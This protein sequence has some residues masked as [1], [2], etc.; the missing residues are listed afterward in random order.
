MPPPPSPCCRKRSSNKKIGS[1]LKI[2]RT[3]QTPRVR[4]VAPPAEPQS[5]TIRRPVPIADFD[6]SD[7]SVE[8]RPMNSILLALTM[9]CTTPG[10]AVAASPGSK[11]MSGTQDPESESQLRKRQL[12]GEYGRY[13]ANNDLTYYHL[14]IRVSPE[15]KT[16]TGKVTVGFRMLADDHRIQLDLNSDLSVDKIV[17]DS[18]ELPFEREFNAVF[19]DNPDG[20]KAGEK[21]S[22]D[23]HYSGAPKSSSRFGGISFDEDPAGRPWMYTACEGPGSSYRWP[24]KDQWRD[25][26]ESMDISVA[27]PNGLTD[28]SNG[29]YMG[30]EDLGDGFTRWKWRVHYPIN[31]YNVSINVA[32]YEHFS[33][34]IGELTL[35]YYALPEDLK[36]AKKQFAQAKP[37][38]E[39]FQHY[40]GEYPFIKDGYKLVQVPY[41]GWSTNPP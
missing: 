16:I 30:K 23:F 20:F 12:R 10:L 8:W 15:T 36:K 21:Y 26:V 32:A 18:A 4:A 2:L 1:K 39:T 25:E 37:M 33:D 14:D 7:P 6:S 3:N 19:I 22:L 35:D 41:S 11:A 5:T 34:Q 29:R 9:L 24:C 38:M 31:S 27:V 13:R 28:V 17:L 40:F